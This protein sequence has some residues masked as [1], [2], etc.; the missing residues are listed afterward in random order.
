[1]VCYEV[2]TNCG[3]FRCSSFLKKSSGHIFPICSSKNEVV[4]REFRRILDVLCLQVL[5]KK[6]WAQIHNFCV[7]K[8]SCLLLSSDAVWKFSLCEG[9]EKSSGRIF[10]I[11]ASKNEV[12]CCEIQAHFGSSLP[13]SFKEKVVSAIPQF[14]RP[15]TK[16]FAV[17][18]RRMLE[19]SR[20]KLYEKSSGRIC[21]YMRPKMKLFAVKF[22]RILVLLCLQV[23][24]KTFWAQFHD[25]CVQKRSYLP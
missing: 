9:Y 23:L 5:Q 3:S 6:L 11:C 24:K 7:Q 18:F 21:R 20:F 16:L 2:Q 14:M 22:I 10:P 1:M 13:A 15:K 19:L 25:L 4:C 12:V 17:R 8:R